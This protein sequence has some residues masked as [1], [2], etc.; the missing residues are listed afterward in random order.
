MGFRLSDRFTVEATGKEV[1]LL[2]SLN[3]DSVTYTI[4]YM[5]FFES[6]V[7]AL[8]R[9]LELKHAEVARPQLWRGMHR[10]RIEVGLS[11]EIDG[12]M[13]W[14]AGLHYEDLNRKR[15]SVGVKLTAEEFG[16]LSAACISLTGGRFHADIPSVSDVREVFACGDLSCRVYRWKCTD[17]GSWSPWLL[18]KE[19]CYSEAEKYSRP[20][21]TSTF[22]S[23]NC[24]SRGGLVKVL[25]LAVAA[26]VYHKCAEFAKSNPALRG[27]KEASGYGRPHASNWDRS[28][29][30]V[31]VEYAARFFSVFM[32]MYGDRYMLR[33]DSLTVCCAVALS[34]CEDRS[35][36][37]GVLDRDRDGDASFIDAAAY[38]DGLIQRAY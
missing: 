15:I 36:V 14:Y 8:E 3:G 25:E 38:V 1:R 10:P 28:V 21:A 32:S 5:R 26:L 6:C 18:L 12:D 19:M 16:K 37:N 31:S 4:C 34:A 22:E 20:V 33:P 29:A 23:F 9:A 7:R 35:W 13:Y 30:T 11:D 17:D 24:G 27:L 2:N